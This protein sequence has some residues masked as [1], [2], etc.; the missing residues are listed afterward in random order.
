[1][2]DSI[3][4]KTLLRWSYT[5]V[6]R[7]RGEVEG[8]VTEVIINRD[9]ETREMSGPEFLTSEVGQQPAR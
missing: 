5:W 1:M 8:R 2:E 6:A 7:D 9:Q 3:T 4:L